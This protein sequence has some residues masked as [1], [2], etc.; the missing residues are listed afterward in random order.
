MVGI[1]SRDE[2]KCRSGVHLV[3]CRQLESISEVVDVDLAAKHASG[4]LDDLSD[5]RFH[6]LGHRAMHEL[7][8]YH[9]HHSP[10]KSLASQAVSFLH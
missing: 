10:V 2:E 9:S 5:Q 1:V 4:W 8:P 3:S 7:N 6:I